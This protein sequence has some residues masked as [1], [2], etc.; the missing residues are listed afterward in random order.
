M[1][2]D[3]H[4]IADVNDVITRYQNGLPRQRVRLQRVK[5]NAEWCV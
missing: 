2:S 5:A 1:R 4:M 3:R